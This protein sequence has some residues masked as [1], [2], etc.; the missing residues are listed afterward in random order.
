MDSLLQYNWDKAI[1]IYQAGKKSTLNAKLHTNYLSYLNIM[2]LYKVNGAK[3]VKIMTESQYKN[4]QL[5]IK[6]EKI[7]VKTKEELEAQAERIK[8]KFENR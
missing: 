5:G 8:R 6:P 3:D 4:A 2:H 7:K 1:Q